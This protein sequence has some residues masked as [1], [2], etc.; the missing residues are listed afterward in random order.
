MVWV[1]STDVVNMN[2]ARVI[3]GWVEAREPSLKFTRKLHWS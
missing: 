1:E 2:K 3:I